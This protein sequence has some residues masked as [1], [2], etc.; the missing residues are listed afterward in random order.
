[1]GLTLTALMLK[2]L[3]QITEFLLYAGE[4]PA[5]A[6]KVPAFYID[7]HEVSNEEFLEFTKATGYRT[8]AEVLGDSF[9]LT[10]MQLDDKAVRGA[11]QAVPWWLSVS[12]A[13][14]RHP[15]GPGQLISTF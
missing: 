15:E 10:G 3:S 5:R 14:W 2:I 13:N 1:M 11:V 6:M 9:L 7:K 12:N 4:H 8:E